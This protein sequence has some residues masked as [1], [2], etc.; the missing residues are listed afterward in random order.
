MDKGR[1]LRQAKC[2]GRSNRVHFLRVPE[3][4]VHQDLL[5]TTLHSMIAVVVRVIAHWES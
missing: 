2:K 1:G 5:I 3:G 4:I